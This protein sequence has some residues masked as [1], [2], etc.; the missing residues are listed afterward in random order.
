[1]LA[2]E[3][4]R[5]TMKRLASRYLVFE[6]IAAGGMATVHYGVVLGQGGFRRIVAIKRLHESWARD[7]EFAAL[8]LDEAKMASRIQHPNV[9]S[10]LDVVE[11][12][13]ELYIVMEYV[14]GAPLS[15]LLKL[16]QAERQR[17]P[18]DV[19]AAII[20]GVLSGLHA[21]HEATNDRGQPL[22][23]VHRDVS[24][25]N[26]LVGTDGLAKVVDFGI[27][28]A[29]G[30]STTTRDGKLKGKL[31]YM[32][33]EQLLGQPATRRSDLW[34]AS[35]V[36]WELLVGQRL[37]AGASEGEIVAKVAHRKAPP[38]R[39]LE[40]DVVP[41]L[42]RVVMRGLSRN[43]EHR[44]ATA[45]EMALAL[46][47][48]VSLASPARVGTWVEG[49]AKEV[50]AARAARVR[51]I[52]AEAATVEPGPTTERDAERAISP[53]T[54]LTPRDDDLQS[55]VRERPFRGRR[56]VY[57]L[58]AITLASLA[59]AAWSRMNRAPTSKEAASSAPRAT[60]TS[61]PAPIPTLPSAE[62]STPIA[63]ASAAPSPSAERPLVVKHSAPVRKE[64]RKATPG[65]PGSR[66]SPNC[67]SQDA[68]GIWHIKPDCL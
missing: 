63:S 67:Y 3:G 53:P 38:P 5:S 52:E 4:S 7:S 34:S 58:V 8:F 56:A 40:K 36:L 15:K 59:F 60:S 20:A 30:R 50:I 62:A 51:A 66:G 12:G 31:A 21:A 47:D 57:V 68:E 24:P 48:A 33:P 29:A 39:E 23:I 43:P 1:M 6:D 17:V 14:P 49:L 25:Q 32:A 11:E 61:T 54:A 10:V 64:P 13:G 45:R 18:Q 65:T 42:E 16:T 27:A 41:E 55:V 37:F 44:F 46:E 2:V 26:I 35:V 22:E 9:V 28:K 19:A